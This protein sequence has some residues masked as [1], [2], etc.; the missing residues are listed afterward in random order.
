MHDVL[1]SG[2]RLP[3]GGFILSANG[4]TMLV[5]QHDGNLVVYAADSGRPL[6]ASGTQGS[7]VK[8]VI[9]QGDGNLVLLDDNDG[10]VWA[11][12]TQGHPGAFLH[13]QDDGNVV[14]VT[15][16]GT[17]IWD[18]GTYGYNTTDSVRASKSLLDIFGSVESLGGGHIPGVLRS[19]S[20]VTSDPAF[21]TAAAA[22]E[23]F[24]VGGPAGAAA[25]ATV[26]A[27]AQRVGA[28]IQTGHLSAA[29]MLQAASQMASAGDFAMNA[30]A[31]DNIQIPTY[32]DL[33]NNL[34]AVDF[35][36]V[37]ALVNTGQAKIVDELGNLIGGNPNAPAE[38]VFKKTPQYT[39]HA[40]LKELGQNASAVTADTPYATHTLRTALQKLGSAANTSLTAPSVVRAQENA[41]AAQLMH[42]AWGPVTPAPAD[43]IASAG[44]GTTKAGKSSSTPLLI[45]I[46]A[47]VAALLLL[48]R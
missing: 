21:I 8:S 30:S 11:S 47:A 34:K 2:E 44:W 38:I 43:K 18:T 46:G 22:L 10:P 9:M 33:G 39:M 25:F 23:G 27:A 15:P 19:I 36:D 4:R 6:W 41:H 32:D 37:Q 26:V 3:Q 13:A 5:L 14:M 31:A 45:G 7:G 42:A 16:D 20:D 17:P 24:A 40:T 28:A 29:V 1:S 35:H 12:A 48:R